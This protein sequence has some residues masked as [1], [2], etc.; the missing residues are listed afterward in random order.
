MKK[1]FSWVL[2]L[3]LISSVF[4]APS[5]ASALT[6]Y[7]SISQSV[8]TY[9]DELNTRL[10]SLEAAYEETKNGLDEIFVRNKQDAENKAANELAR[11]ASEYS[12][13]INLTNQ[14]IEAAKSNFSKY[15]KVKISR[16]RLLA[17]N[18]KVYRFLKCPPTVLIPNGQGGQEYAVRI[19][20]GLLNPLIGTRSTK[21]TDPGATIAQTDFQL[22]DI[23]EISSWENSFSSDVE[24]GINEGVIELLTPVEYEQTRSAIKNETLNLEQLTKRLGDARKKVQD[25]REKTNQL[26][27]LARDS[28]LEQVTAEYEKMRDFYLEQIEIAEGAVVASGRASKVPSKFEREFVAAFQFNYNRLQLQKLIDNPTQIS[29][30]YKTVNSLNEIYDLLDKS[31]AI[32]SKYSYQKAL[33]FNSQ[34]GIAFTRNAEYRSVYKAISAKYKKSSGK[35]LPSVV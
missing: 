4:G 5:N 20:E 23:T 32:E 11:V 7:K 26:N 1:S 28:K 25:E 30:S 10:E 35:N 27:E 2:A 12:P 14:K 9:L 22:G 17:G 18:E 31:E 8:A 6:N 13:S 15:A 33:Q 34:V 24:M 19:C 16:G 29:K 3:V 21:S